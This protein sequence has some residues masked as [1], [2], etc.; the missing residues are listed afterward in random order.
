MASSVG[1]FGQLS[2]DVFRGEM[3]PRFSPGVLV[4][5]SGTCR[6]FRQELNDGEL[7]RLINANLMGPRHV[8]LFTPLIEGPFTWKQAYRFRFLPHV[9]AQAYYIRRGQTLADNPPRAQLNGGLLLRN[10]L[11]GRSAES[12]IPQPE[13]EVRGTLFRIV[14]WSDIQM[15]DS[16]GQQTLLSG[17]PNRVLIRLTHDGEFLYALRDDGF[18]IR[19]NPVTRESSPIDTACTRH[20]RNE[21]FDLT[22]I[23]S[24]TYPPSRGDLHALFFRVVEVDGFLSYSGRVVIKW[25]YGIE[26]IDPSANQSR[27]FFLQPFNL[28]P[29]HISEGKLYAG[30]SKALFVFDLKEMKFEKNHSFSLLNPLLKGS[31]QVVGIQANQ[32][33]AF[34]LRD[35]FQL[36]SWSIGLNSF[37]ILYLSGNFCLVSKA[38][39]LALLNLR[40]GRLADKFYGEGKEKPEVLAHLVGQIGTQLAEEER[41]SQTR[42]PPPSGV[43][44]RRELNELVEKGIISVEEAETYTPLAEQLFEIAR[45]KELYRI[46][47]LKA[48]Q[49]VYQD[50]TLFYVVNGSNVCVE[51]EGVEKILKG[52]PGSS[53]LH[54]AHDG[55]NLYSLRSDGALLTWDLNAGSYLVISTIHGSNFKEALLLAKEGVLV[56]ALNHHLEIHNLK[57]GKIY[58]I[59][60]GVAMTQMFI[61]QQKLYR[62]NTDVHSSDSTIYVLNL[63][64]GQSEPPIL[65]PQKKLRYCKLVKENL[66]LVFTEQDTLLMDLEG[67]LVWRNRK[68]GGCL[69]M[70][71]IL[72]ISHSSAF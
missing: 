13:V 39:V 23:A 29:L 48:Q 66:L 35:D 56:T 45:S 40:T 41:R 67:R 19:W 63:A 57:T 33:R 38:T 64:T 4:A 55:S 8:A 44:L 17:D 49:I 3:V 16:L 9:L 2:E 46:P 36:K 1:P 62:Y 34:H 47:T 32:I 37:D 68:G 50:G 54:L 69:S 6:Y 20:Q 31:D 26:I 28:S 18:V 58:S 11:P 60:D 70:A 72:N 22:W 14:H 65:V 21:K 10:G 12:I 53:L 30:H 5:L 59:N 43:P 24:D 52:Q 15:V 42:M 61:H 7:W 71:L 51:K 25:R 27:A